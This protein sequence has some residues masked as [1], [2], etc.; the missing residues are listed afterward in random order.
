MSQ[1]T[2]LQAF[3]PRMCRLTCSSVF[4]PMKYTEIRMTQLSYTFAEI[5]IKLRFLVKDA[6]M[7][8]IYVCI[9]YTTKHALTMYKVVDVI[10]LFDLMLYVHGKQLRSCWDGQL[11]NEKRQ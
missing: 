6:L 10:F 4:L 5:Q 9:Q 1:Q 11:L 8:P 3:R 7:M 2:C